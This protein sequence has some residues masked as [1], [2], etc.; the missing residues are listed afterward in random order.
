MYPEAAA[1]RSCR[2]QV[3]PFAFSRPSLSEL[4]RQMLAAAKEQF[5]EHPELGKIDL[6]EVPTLIVVSSCTLEGDPPRLGPQVHREPEMHCLCARPT[7]T[8]SL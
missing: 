5:G 1:D 2:S 8:T 4:S 6:M 7:S 3:L